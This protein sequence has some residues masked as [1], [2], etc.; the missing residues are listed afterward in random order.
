[1]YSFSLVAFPSN[2]ERKYFWNAVF[3]A[4]RYTVIISVSDKVQ[5]SIVASFFQKKILIIDLPNSE[6]SLLDLR[7]R[8]LT[9]AG[10]FCLRYC[11]MFLICI[12]LITF[13]IFFQ[14]LLVFFE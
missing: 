2:K 10:C 3:L 1:M 14:R 6:S 4:L 12:G 5:Y 13:P 11:Y 9:F 8:H 7:K